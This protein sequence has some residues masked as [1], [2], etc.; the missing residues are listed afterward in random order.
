VT[1]EKLEHVLV[2]ERVSDSAFAP[3]DL[4]GSPEGVEDSLL[5]G[6]HDRLE[7]V[8]QV[9]VGHIADRGRTPRSPA[10]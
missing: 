1:R 5:G 7:D 8:V 10:A 2:R 3:D 9:A 4:R 6:V